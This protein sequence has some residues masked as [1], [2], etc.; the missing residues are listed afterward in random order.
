MKY[1]VIFVFSSILFIGCADSPEVVS[2]STPLETDKQTIENYMDSNNLI[3]QSTSEGVYYI[4]DIPG[5]S[6]KPNIDSQVTVDYRGYLLD[7]T[8]FDEN[9]NFMVP[10]WQVIDGWQIGIPQFGIGGVGTI[11]IPSTLAYDCVAREG[12][13]EN[14]ILVF[15]I[16]L[17]DFE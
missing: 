13:P 16:T 4:I 9:S 17:I 1:L 2:C 14:S 8:E 11:F 7:G 3:G 15:D 5:S 12:I 10:L 6:E